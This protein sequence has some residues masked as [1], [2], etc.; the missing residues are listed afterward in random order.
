M[1]TDLTVTPGQRL[2]L[3]FFQRIITYFKTP[4]ITSYEISDNTTVSLTHRNTMLIILDDIVL[5]MDSTV[6]VGFFFYIKNM[7]DVSIK[8]VNTSCIIPP[9]YSSII[10]NTSLGF[11]SIDNV[12]TNPF[13]AVSAITANTIIEPHDNG[14][15]INITSSCI[16]SAPKLVDNGF[17][18]YIKNSSTDVSTLNCIDNTVTFD[19]KS[20]IIILPYSSIHAVFDG[21]NYIILEGKVTKNFRTI[22]TQSD[23]LNI[24]DNDFLLVTAPVIITLPIV[25]GFSVYIRR[26]FVSDTEVV[27]ITTSNGTSLIDDE[28]TTVL[29]SNLDTVLLICDGVNYFSFAGIVN[30]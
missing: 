10:V 2:N 1:A 6:P 13:N 30:G 26:N 29:S 28:T 27:S 5:T 8:L 22:T 12:D 25:K 24:M 21:T 19:G 7:S 9:K 20:S 11:I 16:I 14:K 3:D 17:H 23:A 4:F 18:F 15:C